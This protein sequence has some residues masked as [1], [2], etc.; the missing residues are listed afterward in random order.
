M[1]A[2]DSRFRQRPPGLCIGCWQVQ[3]AF[4]SHSTDDKTYVEEVAARL[5]RYRAR[6]DTRAFKPGEDFRDAIRRVMDETEVFVLFVSP[7]SLASSW[8]Q[9]EIDEAELRAI[10]RAIR[11]GLAIFI[12]GPVDS[13]RL[14]EW[15]AR[16]RAVAHANPGQSA[17]TIESLLL[18]AS[19]AEAHP[20]LGR[21]DDLQ[22][23]IRKLSGAEPR[24]RILIMS[25]LEG[26]GRRS[27][28]QRLVR[29]ALG[30]DFGPILAL[31]A[32]GTLEDL[33]LESQVS[34][35][36]LTLEEAE[37]EITAFRGLAPR[38]QAREVA[39]Q[40]IFLAQENAAPCIVDHGAMLD[41]SGAYFPPFVDLLEDYVSERD[42]YLCLVHARAPNYRALAVKW[43]FFERKLKPLAL[44]DAQALVVRLLRDKQ[45]HAE[46][47]QAAA[48]A[49]AS[50]G[51]PPAAYFIA[52]QVEDYGIDVVLNDA[53][54]MSDFTTRSFRRFLQDLKLS[55][56]HREVLVY[57]SSETRLAIQGI[58]TA[59]GRP[60]EGIAKAVSYL[61]DLNL[62]EH[63]EN[64]YSVSGPIQ[65]A[66]RRSERGLGRQW[67]E[68]AFGRLE[69]EFWSDTHSFPPISVVDATLRAALRVGLK[70]SEGYGALVRP[71]LLV[72]AADEMYH[73]K[74]YERALEYVERAQLMGHPTAQMDEIRIK[75]LAQLRRFAEA[76][77]ALRDYRQHGE[78][79]Q[80]YLEGFVARKDGDHSVACSKF[81]R[82]YA[83]GDRST[84]LL[85][86]YADSLL[87]IN[88]VDD[89]AAMAR[90]A[91][92]R[93]PGNVY[94]LDLVS[95]IEIA[96]GTREDA[97]TAL[98][99]LEAADL[100]RQFIPQRRIAYLI[101]RRGGADAVRRAVAIGEEAIKRRS[102]PL[103]AYVMLAHALVRA[104]KRKR[105]EE[106]K[107]E[108]RKRRNVDK[109]RVLA[110]LDLDAAIQAGEWRRA[111]QLLPAK[112]W[113]SEARDYAV[114]V[115]ELKAT[116]RNLLL[117]ERKEAER[118]VK[119]LRQ[120]SAV[121]YRRAPMSPEL[122]E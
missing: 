61:L 89:A 111:E 108:I 79:R 90:T 56:I 33:F 48:L 18:E 7:K 27:F 91:L 115:Y 1:L 38:Q 32:T 106:I 116:D 72:N 21:N 4:L 122:Y 46:S 92:E 64:E 104:K 39:E 13:S 78:R 6:I 120:G 80:S 19:P 45:I 71:S 85:R 114:A 101:Y 105:L 24:P 93:A 77:A 65:T 62:L 28:G 16:M 121:D 43:A 69:A 94:I 54:R 117:Q 83:K 26:M 66:V 12:D 2:P 51:Y 118:E 97:E 112:L 25:G 119:R 5:T 82:G 14:P 67:Y 84:S 11:R 107:A 57:L 29:D 109:G 47:N 98:E 52:D 55:A 103:E 8:V 30:L 75:S 36:I 70:R 9:F 59:T 102:A 20:F 73:R 50:T 100:I 42:V 49:E 58:A 76:R 96:S 99:A 10:R 15:L 40:L 74:E 110:E 87:R 37:R 113:T 22:R 81:Q 41:S 63:H 88:A 31:P 68:R 95:R 35:R 86:D 60:L 3:R 53:S 34:S 23:G 44:P 17:R